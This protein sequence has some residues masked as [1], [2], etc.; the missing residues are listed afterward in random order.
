M[1]NTAMPGLQCLSD[2]RHGHQR[3]LFG[4][5]VQCC[6]LR[7]KP[8]WPSATPVPVPLE[9]AGNTTRYR[10]HA[11]DGE[12]LISKHLTSTFVSMARRDLRCHVIIPNKTLTRQ[13][14]AS[15]LQ[16]RMRVLKC[17]FFVI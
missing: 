7:T 2:R 1:A 16:S 14:R 3:G 15:S 8:P 6:E 17:V 11:Y 9:S 4:G 10:G 12:L 13:P 5:I